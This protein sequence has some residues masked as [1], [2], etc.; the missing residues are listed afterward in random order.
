MTR[1]SHQQLAGEETLLGSWGALAARSTGA[2]LVYTQSTFAA[3][4]PE[5]EPLN[6]AILLDPPTRVSASVAAAE[7]DSVFAGVGVTS[8][9]LWVPSSVAD[10]ETPDPAVD[11]V[12]GM[13]RDTTTLVMTRELEDGMPSY[14][15]VMRTTVEM[16]ALAGDMPVPAE[17]VTDPCGA[18]D[19]DGWVL[20]YD[21]YAVAGAWTYR[22]GSDLGIYAVGTVPEWRRRGLARAMMLHVL[23]DA[24]RHGATTASLQSTPMG[25]PLYASLGF[26]PVGRYEEWVPVKERTCVSC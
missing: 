5:W 17:A 25:A 19:V 23:A 24:Y 6:N 20:I 15:G 8:W 13:T 10:F 14:S 4:F 2:H 7:A 1:I 3:V 21:E 11:E 16:A 9:A 18:S 22:N 26:R 12:V